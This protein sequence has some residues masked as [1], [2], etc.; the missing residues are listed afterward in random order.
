MKQNESDPEKL[1]SMYSDAVKE[2]TVLTRSAVVNQLY[3]GLKVAVEAE[4]R[5]E[6]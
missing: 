2:S 1:R 5:E 6:S 4:Q 3:G